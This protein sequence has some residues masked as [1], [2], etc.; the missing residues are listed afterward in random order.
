MKVYDAPALANGAVS[1]KP[2]RPATA[3]AHDSPE[4]RVVLFR[5]EPGEEVPVHASASTVLLT[6]VSGQG[7][8][9]GTSGEHTVHAGSIVAYE[10]HEPHGMRASAGEFVIAAT[11]T[12]RPAAH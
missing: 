6:V 8:V 12:P 11:I 5:L 1:A 4:A 2:G 9:T 10:P 3:L 7:T